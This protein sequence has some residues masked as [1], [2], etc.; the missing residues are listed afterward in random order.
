MAKIAADRH[1]RGMGQDYR[2]KLLVDPVRRQPGLCPSALIPAA[3]CC[4]N[5]SNP[6][7]K[8]ITVGVCRGTSRARAGRK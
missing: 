5:S 8:G 6:G 7:G 2:A 3:I 1:I 4:S